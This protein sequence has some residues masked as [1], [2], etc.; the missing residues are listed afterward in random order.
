MLTVSFNMYL[1]RPISDGEMKAT[2]RVIHRS[3]RLFVAE[4]VL[5]DLK[6]RELARGS[7]AFVK[8]NIPLSEELGYA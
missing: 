4:S 3:R 2:G 8:S 1:I 7:G 6:G 5:V